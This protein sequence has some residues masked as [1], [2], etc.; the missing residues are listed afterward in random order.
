MSSILPKTQA[1]YVQHHLNHFQLN[2]RN[3][4]LGDGG[5]FWTLHLD[6]IIVTLIVGIA[7]MLLFHRVVKSFRSDRPGKL[8]TAIELLVEYIQQLAQETSNKA[9]LF[10]APLALTIFV[11]VLLLNALDLL[12]ID[13]IPRFLLYFGIEEFRLVPTDDL[14][15]TFALSLSVFGLII[16]Y[17]YKSKGAYNLATEILTKPFGIWFFPINV[18][19]RLIE[20]IVKP[21]S[22]SLRLFGNIFAGELIFIIIA[23]IPW[24]IQWSVGGVW[25]VF[26]VL[27]ITIQAFVFMMLTIIYLGMAKEA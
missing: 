6:T 23:T 14:N 7:F 22:L 4:K 13:L 8:Q 15:F 12:P 10:V 11:L 1:E 26:H 24:W 16:F 19:F 3:F 17:N 20:E 27:I 5:G 18:I 2:L 21:L 9:N 25:S